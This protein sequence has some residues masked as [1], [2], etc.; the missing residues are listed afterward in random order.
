MPSSSSVMRHLTIAAV[1]AVLAVVTGCSGIGNDPPAP[2]DGTEPQNEYWV[3][4]SGSTGVNDAG[5]YGSLGVATDST[6]PGAREY[7]VSWATPDGRLWLFGGEGRDASGTLGRLNDLWVYS[8]GDGR[9][10]WIK[11]S[12]MV[13]ASGDYGVLPGEPGSD[14][15]PGARR[16]TS[17]WTGADGRLWLFGGDGFDA[18]G[19]NSR[20]NDLWVYDP[21]IDMWTWVAGSNL[22]DDPGDHGEKGD[23]DPGNRPGARRGAV[24]WTDVDGVLWLLGGRGDYDDGDEITL[25]EWNDLWTFEIDSD[26][27]NNGVWT[28]VGGDDTPGALG[29]YGIRGEAS[30]ANAPGARRDSVTW[31]GPDR[32]LWLFGGAGYDSEGSASNLNDLWQFDIDAGQW[33]WISGESGGGQ[34]SGVYGVRGVAAAANAPGARRDAVGWTD[35]EGTLWLF[36]GRGRNE[37][38]AVVNLDDLWAYSPSTGQWTWISGS[39]SGDRPAQYGSKGVP[40]V[41]AAP[42]SRR[43]ATSA[44]AVSGELWLYGG[45]SQIAGG[46]SGLKND[47]WRYRP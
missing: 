34:A 30:A 12:S 5:V 42:G 25:D 23:P 39:K 32:T 17:S 11:G 38:G 9:W 18:E 46:G 6:T 24:T 10:T 43:D 15:T 7:P 33:T 16:R 44:R 1:T 20:Q 29:V 35:Q 31:V 41:A 28:W 14:R 19:T 47:L 22:A 4:V 37:A 13:N 21:Q 36:G 8:P 45:T 27:P 40:S 26:D 3:W 2:T